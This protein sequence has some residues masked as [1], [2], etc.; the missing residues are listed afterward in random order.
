MI[1]PDATLGVL[2]GGQLGRMFCMA[3]HSMGYRVWVFDPD[4]PGAAPTV[5]DIEG[6]DPRAL[7]VSPD[8]M[9][10]YAA[11]FESGNG[12]TLLG[13]GQDSDALSF[14]PNVLADSRGS[15]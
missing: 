4:S 14:P 15:A 10:V 5:L 1:F 7:A 2:G 9:S 13:G 12:S 3:A 6:E 11:V 8:G